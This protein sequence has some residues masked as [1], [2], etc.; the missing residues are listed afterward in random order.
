LDFDADNNQLALIRF[1][2]EIGDFNFSGFY[3]VSE[4]Q[5]SDALARAGNHY[6]NDKGPCGTTNSLEGD[7]V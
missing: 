3:N 2:N 7:T 4:F 1:I 5:W 6:I